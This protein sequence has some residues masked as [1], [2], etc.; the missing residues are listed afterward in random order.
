MKVK[1]FRKN[2]SV[3]IPEYQTSG[4]V[5]FDLSP[6]EDA[7]IPPHEIRLVPTGLVICTPGG[8][9]LAIAARSSTPLKRGLMIANGI[10][11]VDQDFCGPDDEIK[12][13]LLNFTD[14]PVEIKKGDRIAQGLF[15]TLDMVEWEVVAQ[16]G[17]KTR[18][19]FG[20]TG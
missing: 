10:G 20:S 4:S 5:A 12:L 13:Q 9:M 14:K 7:I 16:L 2:S 3:S 17:G 11:I 6:S 19:G 18:G 8:A 1:I 15:L